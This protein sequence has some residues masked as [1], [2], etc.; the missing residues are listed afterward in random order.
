MPKYMTI[1]TFPI[2]MLTPERIV[3]IADTFKTDPK[4]HGYRS[5]HSLS[6]GRIVWLLEAPSRDAV[7]SWCEANGLPIDGMTEL[8]LEGHVGIIRSAD[9][10]KAGRPPGA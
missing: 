3:E 6:E 10:P 8:E 9:D 1:H 4:V 2:G 7:V 5:F